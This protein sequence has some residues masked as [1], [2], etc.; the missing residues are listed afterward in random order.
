MAS[1]EG[2]DTAFLARMSG[3]SRSHT[4]LRMGLPRLSAA[5]LLLLSGLALAT[6]VLGQQTNQ[7]ID[8]TCRTMGP[9]VV[10]AICLSILLGSLIA[11]ALMERRL[12]ADGW[13]L[14]HALSEPI[15]V[16]RP[17]P[18]SGTD[19]GSETLTVRSASCSRLIAMSG[20]LV[21][22]LL[23]L[24]F[25]VFCLYSFGM[26]CTMPAQTDAITR[27]LYAGL[28]LF[29]PYI[30]N[31]FSQVFRPLFVRGAS[32]AEPGVA[33]QL[34]PVPEPPAAP[35]R[36]APSLPQGPV[37]HDAGCDDPYGAA[38]ALIAQFEG[39]M[40]HAYPDPASGGAPW[41]IGYGCTTLHG[42]PVQPGDTISRSDAETLLRSGVRACATHLA[43][44]IPHWEEMSNDQRCAL[45]SFSWNLGENF[46]G[47]STNFATISRD[48]R[49]RLW[50]RVPDDLQLYC[51]P[52]SAVEAG[53]R[54]RRQAEAE[55]WRK[56]LALL[57]PSQP[58]APVL[59]PPTTPTRGKA[60]AHPNP[61]P[62]P[63]FDQLQM[64]DGQG[65]RDCFSAS[66]AMLAGFWG[67]E[68]DENTYNHLRQHY[69]D[70]TS[71]EA[72]LA[73]LRH[74]GFQAEFRTDGNLDSLKREI[75]SGRPVAVGW[76]HHGP[77]SAPSGGGHWTVVI[78]Y[79]AS[80]VIMNDP[81]GSCDLVNGG[82]PQNHNGAHQHYSY[83]NW[84][85]RWQPH[86][87]GGWYLCC[88][89]KD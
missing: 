67:K 66:S 70:S 31:Q 9:R 71:P 49:E 68:P 74:L 69:G 25:G 16:N 8:A 5:P 36:A 2:P 27:F 50:T 58:T 38:V 26:T 28:T 60:Q 7:A 80:G 20:M 45:I 88:R 53:L 12:R 6:P 82:Y 33:A 42:R 15:L 34:Q 52:G 79:D 76:L 14:A 41:A 13:S 55:L 21:I 85:P 11:L 84:L 47:D 1:L 65:W 73:A 18:G 19:P 87:S 57:T 32:A 77:P 39:F 64:D 54:R 3:S 89:P 44:T 81:Y 22:L 59:A 23:Y 61:L 24:G 48:L 83:R 35:S 51:N 43:E 29:A 30:A 40:D 75:D 63:Y 62:V 86:N 46:Y 72:Q 10:E 4:V 17:T 37:S 78:G 56:G